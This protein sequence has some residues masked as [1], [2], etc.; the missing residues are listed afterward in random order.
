METQVE[1]KTQ[2]KY[3]GIYQ[4]AHKAGLLDN[5]DKFDEINGNQIIRLETDTKYI[6]PLTRENQFFFGSNLFINKL[7]YFY[8]YRDNMV[9]KKMGIYWL[10]IDKLEDYLMEVYRMLELNDDLICC[11][12][13]FYNLFSNLEIPSNYSKLMERLLGFLNYLDNKDTTDART[14]VHIISPKTKGTKI[15]RI[16]TEVVDLMNYGSDNNMILKFTKKGNPLFITITSTLTKSKGTLRLGEYLDDYESLYGYLVEKLRMDTPEEFMINNL[17]RV[18][19]SREFAEIMVKSY[20][21]K[22]EYK[23]SLSTIS[24]IILWKDKKSEL[25]YTKYFLE[26]Y[27]D[28]YVEKEEYYINFEGINKFFLNISEDYVETFEVKEQINEMYYNSMYELI[29]SFE[30]LYDNK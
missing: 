25:N 11:P 14:L 10:N 8:L 23:Y 6:L 1:S 30:M 17:E 2:T 12:Y 13:N 18:C 3:T 20:L 22:R 16:E 4:Y 15:R 24:G 19:G 28:C 21:L 5:I 9:K 27:P 26:R 29:H 7:N